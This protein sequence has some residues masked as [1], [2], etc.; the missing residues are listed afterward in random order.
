MGVGCRRLEIYLR[1][2]LKESKSIKL[3]KLN[4]KLIMLSEG[5][6]ADYSWSRRS[7]QLTASVTDFGININ[8]IY[9]G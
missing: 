8:F 7:Q 3:I 2:S 5:L 6:A 1:M 4:E 9:C